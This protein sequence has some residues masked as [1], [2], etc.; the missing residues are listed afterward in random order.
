VKNGC[1]TFVHCPNLMHPSR[2]WALL[3]CRRFGLT[4]VDH[5][6]VEMEV[7][8]GDWDEFK[9]TVTMLFW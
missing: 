3:V 5:G 1:L 8:L 6:I 4:L 7:V 9:S 2:L